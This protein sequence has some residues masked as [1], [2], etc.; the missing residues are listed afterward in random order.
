MNHNVANLHIVVSSWAERDIHENFAVLD[1]HSIDVGEANI[2]DIVE[3]L[4][5]QM[6]SKFTKY[7]EAT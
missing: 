2:K 3:Y 6:A 5:V 4:K 7:D 1:A